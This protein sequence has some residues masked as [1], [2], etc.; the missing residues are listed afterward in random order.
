MSTTEELDNQE[1]ENQ[2][3]ENQE[4][5]N[6]VLD[7]P[8]LESMME[9]EFLWEIKLD[10]EY[11]NNETGYPAQPLFWIACKLSPK[12][13]KEYNSYIFNTKEYAENYYNDDDQAYSYACK[14]TLS[15]FDKLKKRLKKSKLIT[16]LKQ[17]QVFKDELITKVNEYLFHPN[18][19]ERFLE[20]GWI[21][22]GEDGFAETLAL[23][24]NIPNYS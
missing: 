3:I 23:E 22:F 15:L 14:Y 24:K 8:D 4:T 12:F 19:V 7:L 10:D 21:T 13:K 11:V 9:F 16:R 20:N 6:Q 18:R 1:L 5:G 17:T 2:E